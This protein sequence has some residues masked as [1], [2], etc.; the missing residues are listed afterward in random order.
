MLN[1]LLIHIEYIIGFLVGILFIVSFACIV[2]NYRNS[3]RNL[4]ISRRD[5]ERSIRSHRWTTIGDDTYVMKI[6][7]GWFVE[8]SNSGFFMSDNFYEL[9]DAFIRFSVDYFLGVE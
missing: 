7:G 1:F 5:V 3:K 6:P 2:D 4:T 8:T 9:E